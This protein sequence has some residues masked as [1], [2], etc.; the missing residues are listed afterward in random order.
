MIGIEDFSKVEIRAGKI[1]SAEVLPESEK[2]LKLSVDF[3]EERP[4]TVVS[5]IKKY[6]PDPSELVGRICGFVTNLEPRPLMGIE[7]EAMILAVTS[8]EKISLLH[9]DGDVLPGARVK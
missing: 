7:S 5:G 8:G 1:L 4:R 6:F 3:G 9:I 2:L